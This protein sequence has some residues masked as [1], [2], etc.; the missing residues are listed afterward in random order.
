VVL[1]GEF[2][3]ETDGDGDSVGPLTVVSEGLLD[4]DVGIPGVP[5]KGV[6]GPSEVPVGPADGDWDVVVIAGSVD[7]VGVSV[8]GALEVIVGVVLDIPEVVLGS[9]VGVDTGEVCVGVSVDFDVV[10]VPELVVE[11]S[12]FGVVGVPELVGLFVVVEGARLVVLDVVDE[13]EVVVVGVVVVVGNEVV[14]GVVDVVVVSLT[15]NEQIYGF[16]LKQSCADHFPPANDKAPQMFS[17]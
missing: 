17:D 6:E 16:T 8:V 5:V 2:W 1:D 11:G 7:I 15:K 4:V 10:D 13:V 12:V 3:V 9:P 14:V